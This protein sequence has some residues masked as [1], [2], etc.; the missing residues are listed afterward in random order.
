[1]EPT[2]GFLNQG[3]AEYGMHAISSGYH[4]PGM[5]FNSVRDYPPRPQGFFIGTHFR[6]CLESHFLGGRFVHGV[7]AL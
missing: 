4:L 1:M 7:A 3:P 2:G 5:F 6:S